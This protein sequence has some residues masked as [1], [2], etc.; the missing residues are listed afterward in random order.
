[1]PQFGIAFLLWLPLSASEE[2]PDLVVLKDGR[3]IRGRVLI[4]KD[5]EGWIRSDGRNHSVSSARVAR[6]ESIPRKMNTYL[7]RVLQIP[8]EGKA[9]RLQLIR[10][11]IA[12]GLVREAKL[13]AWLVLERDPQDEEAHQVLGHRRAAKGWK[14]P[15]GEQWLSFEEAQGSVQRRR[16]RAWELETEHFSL[17]T[18][19]G[20]FDAARLA[21][22][23]ELFYR[24]AYLL[25]NPGA[26][27]WECLTRITVNVPRDARDF[28]ARRSLRVDGSYF[29]KSGEGQD[30]PGDGKVFALNSPSAERAESWLLP[31]TFCAIFSESFESQRGGHVADVPWIVF[32]LEVRPGVRRSG[33]GF[34]EAAHSEVA[35][36][37]ERGGFQ[38]GLGP[39]SG[40]LHGLYPGSLP[41]GGE[42]A[43]MPQG[44]PFLR[45]QT[46]RGKNTTSRFEELFG[47]EQELGPEWRRHLSLL[48]K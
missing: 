46:A 22:D 25:L 47:S 45:R 24:E 40:L 3:E 16:G 15:I 13:E 10:D 34:D 23:L 19:F 8:S 4:E 1:M 43:A 38:G 33:S 27:L 6:V 32:G 35:H 11:L 39:N 9:E 5:A 21:R 12:L 14:I 29:P 18:N 41:P 48:S 28:T 36:Q 44:V 20:V 2:G 42:G 30:R 31:M 37:P 17:R 7:S 26:D